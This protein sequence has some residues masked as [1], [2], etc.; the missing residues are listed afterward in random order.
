M[1][2][3]GLGRVDCYD[4]VIVGG[5]PAGLMCA[6]RC[7]AP[8][9]RV[10][11]IEKK[12]NCGNK[13]LIAGSGQCNITHDGDISGFPARYGSGGAFLKP[14][15]YQFPNSAVMAFFRDRGV[16]VSADDH[17]KV[18]PES[19]RSQDILDCLFREVARAGAV[20]LTGDPVTSI[21]HEGHGF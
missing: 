4:A 1:I 6:I 3:P 9:R 2:Q 8:G 16:P 12:G 18:F 14:A 13:I 15:L 20:I 10:L 17:G 7:S 19:R 5:G 21:R 11:L